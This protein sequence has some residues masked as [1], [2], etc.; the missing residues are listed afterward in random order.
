MRELLLTH[1]W[2][3][4]TQRRQ[5]QNSERPPRLGEIQYKVLK[6]NSRGNL[7][8]QTGKQTASIPSRGLESSSMWINHK[9]FFYKQTV[10]VQVLA[11][12]L[13]SSYITL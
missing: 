2:G 5:G 4:A 8:S 10:W 11:V 6:S 1:P 12:L 13:T 7:V 3:Q 9:E